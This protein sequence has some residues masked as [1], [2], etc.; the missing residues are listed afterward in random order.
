[1]IKQLSLALVAVSVLTGC[2]KQESLIRQTTSGYPEGVFKNTSLEDAKG[3]II[4]G[5]VNGGLIVTETTQN[6]VVCEKTMTGG[7]AIFAQMLIG[8]SYSTTPVRKVRFVVF[9][10]NK[11]VK[12]T[13]QQYIQSQ[14]AFGQIRTQELNGN[15]HRNDI[16]RFLYSLGAY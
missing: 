1:M 12:I 15:N 4:N 7:D 9:Q 8:N 5:C 14:M 16:Q 13:A 10:M 2:P 3:K 11:D 6:H